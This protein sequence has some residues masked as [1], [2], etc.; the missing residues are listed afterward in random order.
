MRIAIIDGVNQDI[1]LNILF[2]EAHYYINNIELDKSINMRTHNI[3]PNYDWSQINDKN[4]DYLFI[5]IALYDAKPGTKFFKQNIYNILQNEIKIINENN[6]KKVFLF[7]NYDYDYDPNDILENEKITLF[8]KR[9][10]NKTKLY[11]KNVIPFP[12]IMFGET[13]IIEKIENT[14]YSET[15]YDRVFF[16]GTL[17]KHIDSQI[18]YCR[19]RKSIYNK[20]SRF[21]YN[22]GYLDY[23][24]FLRE[25]S[26]SKFS[27]DLN[28][29]GDPNKRTFEILSCGSLMISEYNNLK[30]PFEES[31]S[32][33]T[34][35]KNDTEFNDKLLKLKN[36]NELYI[37]CLH[38]QMSIFN[39]YF[40]KKWIREE[41]YKYINIKNIKI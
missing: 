24:T 25:A 1:G 36:D 2:P 23:N 38:N 33:E 21:V 32:E 10:Y 29:V 5:V 31:F 20:I 16:T 41:I 26:S 35:F 4:Y 22:P 8:F 3:N 17:F 14:Y 19:D 12:F 15:K 13:S 30:W 39:K 18:N 7:D 11:N 37:K 6:F 9:N 40:N 34:V 28:G 27:L